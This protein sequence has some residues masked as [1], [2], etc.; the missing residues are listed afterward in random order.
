MTADLLIQLVIA[1]ILSSLLYVI[2]KFF[3]RFKIYNLHGLTF[4]Y[5]TASSFSFFANYEGNK[6]LLP[7]VSNFGSFA[8]VVGLMFIIVFYVA[9]LTAQ[10]AGISVT[11]IAGKMSM[12][13]PITA[14]F[15]LYGDHITGLRIAGM[16]MA[17]IAVYLSSVKSK[18]D[19]S[20]HIDKR[21]WIYPVLLFI[22]SGMVDTSIKISEHYFITPENQNLFFCCLFGAA[23]I[24]G[25]IS[26]LYQLIVKKVKIELKSAI[27]G[28]ILGIVNYYSL[29][30]LVNCLAT[31][32]A[33]SALIFAMVNMLVVF[34]SAVLAFFIFKERPTKLNLAG[35]LIALIA[36]LVLSY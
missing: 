35:M 27:G 33:E 4:N 17:L 13:I 1:S 18:T 11:S 8:L 22:G 32:G 3:D 28:I 9:A 23:G 7:T 31:K 36:I 21:V 10:K 12:I 24:F 25:S 29:V 15:F 2:L 5:I 16:V 26:T 6:V 14:G 30:F 19:E 20:E 34:F